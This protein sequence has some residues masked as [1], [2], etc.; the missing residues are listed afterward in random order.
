[1]SCVCV[2]VIL[3]GVGA[4]VKQL[5]FIFLLCKPRF[6]KKIN[7]FPLFIFGHAGSSSLCGLF[8]SC[9]GPGLPFVAGWCS[10][11]PWAPGCMGSAA[12]VPGLWS[13][14]SVVVVHGLSCSAVCGILLDQGSN[15]CLL[16]W[17]VD[18]LPLSR[19]G[20]CKTRS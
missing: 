2:L 14:R 18:S 10:C 9:G 12:A 5:A 15:L 7:L 19:Q 17:Q 16:N 13:T 3:L 4:C 1:M 6:L 20:P 11:G 8:P